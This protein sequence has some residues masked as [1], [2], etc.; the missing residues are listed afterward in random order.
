MLTRHKTLQ[1]SVRYLNR[2]C[3]S[4]SS[5]YRGFKF[6]RM[7]DSSAPQPEETILLDQMA[8]TSM[9]TLVIPLNIREKLHMLQR[10]IGDKKYVEKLG[11]WMNRRY[12]SRTSVEIP[13][14]L[15]SR[16]LPQEVEGK[17]RVDDI[18][19]SPVYKELKKH[20][21][22]ENDLPE[23][24]EI[25][26]LA[27]AHAEDTRHRLYVRTFTPLTAVA[28]TLHRYTHSWAAI[29][30]SLFEISKRAPDFQPSRILEFGAGPAIGT[31][32]AQHIWED[33][34]QKSICVE[35]S[36]HLAEVGK[37]LTAHLPNVSFQEGLYDSLESVDLIVVPFS[38]VEI[39]SQPA[40]DMLLRNLW[41]R[42]SAG[43]VLHLVEKGT[44]TGFR[45]IHSARELFIKELGIEKFHFV[46]PCP[47]EGVCPMATTG[48]E[49]CHFGQ[50]A[51][52][53]N[54]R[55]F[56]RKGSFIKDKNDVIEEKFSYLSIRKAVGPR[57]VFENEKEA[58]SAA[59][60]SYFWP[61]VV[62]PPYKRGEHV[63]L[64]V[65]SAPHNFERLSVA[66]SSPKHHGY[67]FA[68]KAM[69]GDLWRFPKR[70][71]LPEARPYVPNEIRRRMELLAKGARKAI[72]WDKSM[73]EAD[74]KRLDDME[75]THFGG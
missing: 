33:T 18:L 40:R 36:I 59:W 63:L 46:A 21:D 75:R 65:C 48:R 45:L 34:F 49:W 5:L 1:F 2:A 13:R 56:N 26:R 73:H 4:S 20:I 24:S 23:D 7:L 10:E 3:F 74:K 32:C 57:V 44:P 71:T 66:K 38:L 28:F 29:F 14:V 41:N 42:L 43:G 51:H 67:R 52:A 31:T 12:R 72:D 61:R 39:K 37:Y 64:D 6:D 35:P 47:H 16:L 55:I 30:R 68:R 60:K 27:L 8:M 50:K 25:Y 11:W 17:S 54:H 70:I 15:P 22:I 19:R 9:K 69:W 58:P 62:I 53:L